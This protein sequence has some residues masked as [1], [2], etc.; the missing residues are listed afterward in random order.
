MLKSVLAF[1]ACMSG[2]RC[3]EGTRMLQNGAHTS[4]PWVKL[5][6]VVDDLKEVHSKSFVF[7]GVSDIDDILDL[8]ALFSPKIAFACI[9]YSEIVHS[10]YVLVPLSCESAAALEAGLAGVV[11]RS[12]ATLHSSSMVFFGEMQFPNGDTHTA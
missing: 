2:G 7:K 5:L 11:L 9:K 12:T 6:G 4:A 1:S 10:D 3:I 8:F